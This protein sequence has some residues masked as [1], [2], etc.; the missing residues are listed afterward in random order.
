MAKRKNNSKPRRKKTGREASRK[1]AKPVSRDLPELQ[2]ARALWI[3]NRF[4]EALRL[5]QKAVRKE[6]ANTMALVDA[7]RAFGAR[8]EFEQAEEYLRR[9]IELSDGRAELLEM[10]GQSYRMIGRP[11]P[12]IDCLEQA[13]AATPQLFPARLELAILYERRHRLDDAAEQI[14]AA[15]SIEPASLEAQLLQ[16]RIDRRKEEAGAA[17]KILEAVA[18]TATGHWAT[19]AQAWHELGKL[20]DEAGEFAAA[21]DSVVRGKQLLATQAGP[22][23]QR[24]LLEARR[25]EHL[26]AQLTADDFTQW[27]QAA[28]VRSE[29]PRSMALLT[30]A[31][32]SG[33][34]LLEKVLDS[35]PQIVTSDEQEAFAKYILPSLLLN[36]DAEEPI[37]P[38]HLSRITAG[39]AVEQRARYWR[40][41]SGA[42]GEPIGQRCH[43]DK[44]P[45]TIMLIPGMLRLFPECKILLAI[46]DPRDVVVS[47]FLRYLPLNTV[48]VQFLTL[49]GAAARYRR[50][51]EA[52]LRLRE[53]IGSPW[54]EVRYEATVDDLEGTA[55]QVV[56]F[57]GLPWDARAMSYREQLA[58]RQV[59]SPTYEDVAKPIYRSSIGR[60]RGYASLAG[61]VFDELAP[62]IERLGYDA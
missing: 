26:H 46:R 19:R 20:Y 58:R 57:L 4:P 23:R 59:N 40:Y 47:C 1:S 15:L 55:R 14:E 35:H 48:S 45:S 21:Y 37:S 38:A 25:L 39:E 42:L 31:P 50:D 30:G 56:D 61:G 8:Y 53:V 28:A 34:T 49:E 44:N 51:M 12:A 24:S 11:G 9:L 33:T 7:A 3:R 27:R 6:P 36:L 41:M 62:L 29:P 52:W 54:H 32:R 10:A 2:K 43:V 5:F 18:T 60:W 22:V 13:V 17:E 16:G